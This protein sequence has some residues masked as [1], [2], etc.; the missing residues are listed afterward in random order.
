MKDKFGM[1]LDDHPIATQVDDMEFFYITS[2]DA[3]KT[4][5]Q[6]SSVVNGILGLSS[7]LGGTSTTSCYIDMM[8]QKSE[9]PKPTFALVL[10]GEG[11]QS[12]ITLGDT[13]YADVHKKFD[14]G[15]FSIAST[16]DGW[17]LQGNTLY[18]GD[19]EITSSNGYFSSTTS[20][21]ELPQGDFD[22]Y[23]HQ[24]EALDTPLT[25]SNSGCYSDTLTC[26]ELAKSVPELK[27]KVGDGYAYTLPVSTWSKAG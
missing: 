11:N 15:D 6:D 4:L 1:K 3:T 24:M 8:Y 9:I 5:Y 23:T 19:K 10:S 21:I 14:Y 27:V 22:T 18:L 17:A 16:G 13:N 12:S 2:V 7:P 26:E 20:T 25:C